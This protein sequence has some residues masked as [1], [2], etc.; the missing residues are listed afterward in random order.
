M[1][2]LKSYDV[3]IYL[4]NC[5]DGTCSYWVARKYL[6]HH[7]IHHQAIAIHAGEKID[8]DNDTDFKNKRIAF[9]D[10]CPSFTCLQ[11]LAKIAKD[12]IILDHHASSINVIELI[13]DSDMSNVRFEFNPK[14]AGCQITWNHFYKNY[15]PPWFLEYI[16]DRDLWK[17]TLESSKEINAALH[18][19]NLL[20]IESMDMINTYTTEEIQTLIE[21]GNIILSIAEKSL[22]N[23][24]RQCVEGT[25][26]V[27][28]HIYNVWF[29]TT[30]RSTRSD[31]GNRMCLKTMKNGKLPDFGVI[32]SYQPDL[33]VW[34]ISLRGNDG[35]PDLAKIAT[36]FDGGGDKNAAGFEHKDPFNTIFFT[37]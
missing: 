31:L 35:C 21:L 30:D 19:K 3:I 28:N 22:H 33:S 29:G 7:D 8:I 11:K 12:I 16:A 20:N 14:L 17:F 10:V 6:H 23:T 2:E 32:Y 34:F 4:R 25:F 15:T 24:L 27:D 5:A 36:H 13:I 1:E 9:I 37:S 18:Y 26:T